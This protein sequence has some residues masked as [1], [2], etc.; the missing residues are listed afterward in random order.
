MRDI[1]DYAKKYLEEPCEIFQVKYRR[2]KVLEEMKKYP[3]KTILEIGVGMEPLFPY[4]DDYEKYIMVEPAEEFAENAKRLIE[5]T[6]SKEKVVCI[7]GFFEA[8]VEQIKKMG[9]SFE[10]ILVS[11]LLHEIEKPDDFMNGVKS[12]CG[13]NTV[14]HLNVPNARSIH[15]LVAKEM[16]L[17]ADEHE[18]SDLQKKMQ[19]RICYD[20][21]SL[22]SYVKQ[23]GFEVLDSGSYFPKVLAAGQLEQMLKMNIISDKYFEGMDGIG[24]YFPENGSEIYVQL[25]R[26]D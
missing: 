1:E 12:L 17:I 18:I 19:R 25:K 20:L 24:K 4:V 15:R 13:K 11:G 5:K 9:I 3:H 23:V 10:Y 8:C 14:V 2:K 7:Q 22:S 16:G 26:E 21:D 6:D